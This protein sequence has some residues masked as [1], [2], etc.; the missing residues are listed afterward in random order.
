VIASFLLE[1][2]LNHCYWSYFACHQENAA[3]RRS[4]AR[5]RFAEKACEEEA[6][7]RRRK[8]QFEKA[9]KQW[10]TST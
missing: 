3:K 1:Q 2:Q 6:K 10:K 4:K 5:V 7:K 8:L 9:S